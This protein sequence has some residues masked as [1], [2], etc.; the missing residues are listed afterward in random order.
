MLRTLSKA[1]PP[2]FTHLKSA[3]FA[4]TR[5]YSTPVSSP[6]TQNNQPIN[7]LP[8]SPNKKPKIDLRPGPIK[9]K[10]TFPSSHPPIKAA[11]SASSAPNSTPKPS[12]KEEVI[13]DI[14]DAEKHGILTPPPADADWFKRTLHQA[15]QLIVRSLYVIGFSF[16]LSV[17]ILLPGCEAHIQPSRRN[18]LNQSSYQSWRYAFDK[19]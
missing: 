8:P 1:R 11:R 10:N 12:A 15:I 17:E 2:T 18:C 14:T 3:S 6:S 9:P 13:R 7:T 16:H 5:R 19:V 4:L